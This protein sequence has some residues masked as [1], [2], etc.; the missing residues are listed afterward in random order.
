MINHLCGEQ[1]VELINLHNQIVQLKSQN[2]SLEHRLMASKLVVE[3]EM[4]Q[5]ANRSMLPV[6]KEAEGEV[7]STRIF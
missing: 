1:Q 5:S 2:S 7:V 4:Q 3:G 6:G